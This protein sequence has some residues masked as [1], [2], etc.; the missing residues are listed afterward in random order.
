MWCHGVIKLSLSKGAGESMGRIGMTMRWGLILPLA[1][2]IVSLTISCGNLRAQNALL[3]FSQCVTYYSN[4]RLPGGFLAYP[5]N[6]PMTM[7][8]G[9]LAPAAPPPPD[10]SPPQR[11]SRPRTSQQTFMAD[12]WRCY[13]QSGGS[14]GVWFSCLAALGYEQDPNG[15]LG[16]PPNAVITCR[17]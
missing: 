5:G 14:C 2:G 10:P 13:Q 9:K 8:M 3:D 6:A 16:A 17:Y 7:C 12:R 11:Y 15:L 1:C 4:L